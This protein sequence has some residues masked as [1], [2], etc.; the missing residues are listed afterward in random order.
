MVNLMS[1]KKI[2]SPTVPTT[3]AVAATARNTSDS[4]KLIPKKDVQKMTMA[5]MVTRG[6]P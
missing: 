4:G 1:V 2:G 5:D 6:L 3:N